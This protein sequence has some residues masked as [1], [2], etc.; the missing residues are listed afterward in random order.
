MGDDLTPREVRLCRE[1][2]LA[3][4][5]VIG[6][7]PADETTVTWADARNLYSRTIAEHY[8]RLA[9]HRFP[10]P[11][12]EVPRVVRENGYEFR[13]FGGRVEWRYGIRKDREDWYPWNGSNLSLDT[14]RDLLALPT[15]QRP[16]DEVTP[17]P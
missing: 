4:M 12:V 3:G 5:A 11:M 9:A 16:A 7:P 2:F 1:A 14:L 6:S 17:C 13:V 10:M 8:E 15:E